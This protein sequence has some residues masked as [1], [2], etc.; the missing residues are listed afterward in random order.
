M[1]TD[2]VIAALAPHKGG[3]STTGPK[4][5]RRASFRGLGRGRAS[6]R[7]AMATVIFALSAA[8][9]HALPLSSD[10]CPDPTAAAEAG[11]TCGALEI[12]AAWD[13][14]Q[15]GAPLT[16]YVVR[17]PSLADDPAP[18]P[19]VFLAGG[20]GFGA[21]RA[22]RGAL[23]HPWWRSIRERRDVI[24]VDERG[25]GRSTPA[26]CPA[27]QDA[28]RQLPRQGLADDARLAEQ[29]RVFAACAAEL[30]ADGR[31]FDTYRSRHVG[32]DLAALRVALGVERW[33]LFGLSYGARQVLAAME[34]DPAGTR[35]VLLAGPAM[36][37]AP[38][39]AS[40]AAFDASLAYVL[41]QC[42]ADAACA[43]ESVDVETR[44][45]AVL[46]AFAREP[47][48]VDGLDPA[49]HPGGRLVVTRELA[50]Q[51]IGLMLYDRQLAGTIPLLVGA[52]ERRD[53]DVARAIGGALAGATAGNPLIAGGVPCIEAR[54]HDDPATVAADRAR[55]GVVGLGAAQSDADHDAACGAIPAT[56]PDPADAT[57]IDQGVP[58]LALVGAFDPITPPARV[59]AAI[60]GLPSARMLALPG[61]SHRFF[62][63]RDSTCVHR[64]VGAFFDA[65]DAPPEAACLDALPPVRFATGLQPTG[66]PAA[67]IAAIARQ[68]AWLVG[69]AAALLLLLSAPVV[70]A[71]GAWRRRR[72]P[73]VRGGGAAL[74]ALTGVTALALLALVAAAAWPLLHQ[75]PIALAFGLPAW[76]APWFAL[77]WL[78]AALGL[79]QVATAIAGWRRR[80]LGSVSAVYRVLVG[81]AA[82][83]LGAFGASLGMP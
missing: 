70:A 55:A 80:Q 24:L 20:P 50:A 47:W 82:V 73:A 46:D 21:S 81:S 69:C 42:R 74:L 29:R 59:A 66:K 51:A 56:M 17:V 75:L 13:L 22:W 6:F 71:V 58:I 57:V 15:D 16:M 27:Q 77:S 25:S 60:A 34:A 1:S 2:L 52:L 48:A 37:N 35:S 65:P 7:L 26:V 11:I 12:P 28:L 61:E 53:A 36:P 8:V 3:D 78:I 31:G 44:L 4:A 23:E 9:A 38:A 43:S 79:A 72:A 30:R 40:A 18:D 14:P 68:P 54:P 45:R 33:N 49:S 67:R 5:A 63:N 19:V 39:F 64:L 62:L 76:V 32:R 83:L 10:A 41:A